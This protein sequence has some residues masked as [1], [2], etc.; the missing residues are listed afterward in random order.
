MVGPWAWGRIHPREWEK[1]P[2]NRSSE[3]V[4]KGGPAT[5]GFAF[6]KKPCPPAHGK[7][8]K[9]TGGRT[10][11]SCL[12]QLLGPNSWALTLFS[13][14]PIFFPQRRGPLDYF[15][16][17]T[18]QTIGPRFRVFG[19]GGPERRPTEFVWWKGVGAPPGRPICGKAGVFKTGI[20]TACLGFWPAGPVP[21]FWAGGPGGPW[22]E[23]VLG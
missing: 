14:R 4:L 23:R 12:I 2:E 13:K 15:P 5:E 3:G 6:R 21:I 19:T 18:A 22:P 11:A 9:K 16:R 10:D 1:S 17:A 8:R 20:W 7:K